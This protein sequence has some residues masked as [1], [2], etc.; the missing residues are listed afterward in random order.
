MIFRELSVNGDYHA[1][2]TWL[3]FRNL[4]TWG[5]TLEGG[6]TRLCLYVCMHKELLNIRTIHCRLG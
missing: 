6:M 5:I 3:F 1:W 2:R 4:V